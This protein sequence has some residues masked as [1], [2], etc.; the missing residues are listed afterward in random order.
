MVTKCFSK[1]RVT[2]PLSIVRSCSRGVLV[3]THRFDA[4]TKS[5][6]TRLSRR[7]ALQASGL[8][9]AAGLAGSR[10]TAQESTPSV[11]ELNDAT[12]LFVQTATAGSFTAN[13]G[14]G[15]PTANGT[16]EA[17]GGGDY[18]LTLEGHHG[19]TVYFSD[20]PARSFGN[21]PTQAFLVGLG[22]SPA[23]PPKAALV[24]QTDDGSDSWWP[25]PSVLV[26]TSSCV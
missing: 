17:G 3:T 24:T 23:N 10:A 15:T 5:F 18:Q 4:F 20:R 2:G 22:F 25:V 9:L 13:P 16:P 21:A 14:T 12:F 26:R 11:D 1:I 8:G 19:G 7:T 6:A